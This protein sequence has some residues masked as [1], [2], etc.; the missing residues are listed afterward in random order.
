MKNW[1]DVVV[2]PLTGLDQALRII[3]NSRV[4]AAIVVDDKFRLLGLITD[5]DVRRAILKGFGLS[6]PCNEIM[7]PNPKTVMVGASRD[8]MLS[9]MRNEVLHLLPIVNSKKILCG[10]VTFNEL[11]GATKRENTVVLMA[12][13]RG[14]R[15]RPLTDHRP[16]P[17]LLV[18]GSPILESIIKEFVSQGFGDFVIS[19]NYMSET[20]K[21][22]FGDGSNMGV[23]I[24]YIEEQRPLGTAGSLGLL[25]GDPSV[26]VIVMNADT[27]TSLRFDEI[28]DFHE[29][30]KAVATMVVREWEYQVPYGVVAQVNNEI[31]GLREKPVEKYIVNSGIYVLSPEAFKSIESNRFLDM[32]S[33]FEILILQGKRTMSFKAHD[34]LLDIGRLE[35]YEQAQRDWPNSKND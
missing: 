14:E 12:G 30:E 24:S 4:Q 25:Q 8:L 23:N 15:L 9:I 13:G 1:Q 27:L 17:M 6:T 21:D 16:K 2:G 22:Y 5:G 7:N 10:L 3:D 28:L 29:G 31:S 33:L 34:Y 11:V 32:T 18:G 26:S 35:E 20:I 19:V